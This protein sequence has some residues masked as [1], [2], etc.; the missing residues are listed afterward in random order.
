MLPSKRLLL[1]DIDGTLIAS[2]G[3]GEG[4]L[5]DAMKDRFGVGEDLQ[6]ITLAGATDSAISRVMLEKSGIEATPEN[7][8]ALLDAYLA[9]LKERL[10]RHAGRLLPG[11]IKLLDGLRSRDDCILALLTGN[12]ARGAEVKLTHYGVWDYF[13]FGAFADD[14]HDR[15]ELGKFARARAF[16]K[17]GVEFPSEQIYVIGDTPKDIECGCAIGAWTVAIATGNYTRAELEEHK[18]DFLF[19]DLSETDVVIAAL[20]GSTR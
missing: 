8:A 16:E 6:G 1:F 18:P 15:N 7:I 3:A 20:T 5:R 14:H 2:G 12:V 19:D 11:I 9:A 4:A 10:P 17:H 13:E